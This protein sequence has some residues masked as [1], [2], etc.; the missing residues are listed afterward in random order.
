M[1]WLTAVPLAMAK[2]NYVFDAMVL[3]YP[4]SVFAFEPGTAE[5]IVM[6]NGGWL[7]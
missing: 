7:E 1:V 6:V 2:A 4:R 5:W 3:L